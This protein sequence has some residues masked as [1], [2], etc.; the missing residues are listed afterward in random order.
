[1][2]GK[3]V[4]VGCVVCTRLAFRLVE[5]V[6]FKVGCVVFLR[7]FLEQIERVTVPIVPI[8]LLQVVLVHVPLDV[9]FIGAYFLGHT[10][11]DCPVIQQFT[12]RFIQFVQ[13]QTCI[14]ILLAPSEVAEARAIYSNIK[15][16]ELR[17]GGSTITQQLAKNIYFT[18]EKSALRK[19][20]EIFMAYDL[21]KNLNK[22]T[23]LEL[24]LNTSYFGDGY[25]CVAEASRGYYKKEP[26]D[27]NRN[28]ASM[29]AGIPNAPSAYCPTKH[30]D[31]AKKRQNQVLDKMVRYEFITAKEKE[32][33]LNESNAVEDNK[34]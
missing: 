17:E 30:L 9:G 14:D 26:K 15:A 1:M 7:M 21:E 13:F 4:V 3:K 22:D 29:L 25:Y 23:I 20:A 27:M 24:Y 8:A 18:Q 10:D 6:L 19:I 32:E 16:K 33:I 11:G 2:F 34:D 28:E 5:L 31:L 12:D